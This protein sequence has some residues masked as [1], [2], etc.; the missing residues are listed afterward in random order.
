M[1]RGDAL[2]GMVVATLA[3][4]LGRVS[5]A[6]EPPASA[7]A[8]KPPAGW[9]MPPPPAAPPKAK[10]GAKAKKVAACCAYDDVCC[11]RQSEIDAARPKHVVR[12]VELSLSDLPE[13]LVKEGAVVTGVPPVRVL[14]GLGRPFPWPDGPKK[15]LRMMPPGR[16]GDIRWKSE[17]WRPFFA[18]KKY[19]EMGYGATLLVDKTD[20]EKGNAALSGEVEYTA[21]DQDKE[22]KVIV[23]FVKGKVEGSAELHAT[24]WAHAETFTVADG[25][26]HAFRRKQKEEELVV[27]VLPEVVLGFEAKDAT[28]DGG[29]L[30]SRF[31][32]DVAFTMYML[33]VGEGRSALVTF[34]VF[35][36]QVARWFPRPKGTEKPPFVR[37]ME[38]S[39]SQ[40]SA[41]PEP[42]LR[43]LFF[44]GEAG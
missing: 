37:S 31:S 42:R 14:D 28:H 6:T 19:R 2:L 39:S 16:F 5:L 35:D 18:D 26:V 30:P 25:F 44:E 11:S 4:L 1:R 12:V 40:T 9:E 27:F 33:P 21:I 15:E 10:K 22:G 23:D 20:S 7:E 13:E 17:W 43:V 41:E 32:S 38:L 8:P 36:S 24:R 3:A 29:F 34:R